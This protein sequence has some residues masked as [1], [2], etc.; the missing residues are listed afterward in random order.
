MVER[1][2][3][4]TSEPQDIAVA[5]QTVEF[6]NSTFAL[7]KCDLRKVFREQPTL[8]LSNAARPTGIYDTG[9]CPA[10][11]ASTAGRP[12]AGPRKDKNDTATSIYDTVYLLSTVGV[13]PK[14]I[15][16]M[17]V[18][19]PQLLTLP[20]G[21]MLAVTDFLT[22]LDFEGSVGSLSA[23]P[24]PGWVA[25]TPTGRATRIVL[26]RI[27]TRRRGR[28]LDIS[29]TNR[30]DAAAVLRR[31]AA[32]P[33]PWTWI[34]GGGRRPRRDATRRRQPQGTASTRGS[35]R[36]PWARCERPSAF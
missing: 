5:T 22:S 8:L 21:Q 23:A 33:R 19:W 17:V 15:K 25:A 13:R 4:I 11:L 20:I 27:A 6:M 10:I 29:L 2:P 1:C 28:D 34:F 18:R 12:A 26:G 24:R 16:E 32:P 3:S 30:G 31:V 14:H 36:R 35:S 9:A 7:R